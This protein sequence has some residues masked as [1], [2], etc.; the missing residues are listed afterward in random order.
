MGGL[1]AIRVR[2]PFN[3]ENSIPACAALNTRFLHSR[4]NQDAQGLTNEPARWVHASPSAKLISRRH[5]G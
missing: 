1:L 2:F 3:F 5:L 4:E